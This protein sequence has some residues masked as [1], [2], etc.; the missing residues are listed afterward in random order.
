MPDVEFPSEEF[1]RADDSGPVSIVIPTYNRHAFLRDVL[2]T[3][4][5]QRDVC[6]VLVV[7]DGSSPPV[8]P[9]LT[10][11]LAEYDHLRVV[12][13]TRSLGSCIARNTGI[14]EA[15]G[16]FVFFG[17]DDLILPEDHV[18][19]LLS[20]RERLGADLICGRLLHQTDDETLEDAILLADQHPGPVLDRRHISV[21]TKNLTSA[22]ELPFVNAVFLASRRLLANYQF[23]GHLGG[24]SFSRE[25]NE[26]QLRL[27]R[28]GYRV[29]GTH[30]TCSLH[31]ARHRTEGSGTRAGRTIWVQITS[32]ALNSWQVIDQYY[33]E[34]SPFFPGLSREEMNRRVVISVMLVGLKRR[35]RANS[36]TFNRFAAQIRKIL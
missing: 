30:Q 27:R 16:E 19:V 9:V 8:E 2:P 3:Y 21:A 18:R 31:L 34:I 14:R 26:L 11:L 15:R 6:E 28:A 12:R 4:L 35:A 7:D 5:T 25:D 22:Q 33:E 1:E 17:E 13:H 20:E 24:P 10:E 23:S 36:R 32:S 29:F